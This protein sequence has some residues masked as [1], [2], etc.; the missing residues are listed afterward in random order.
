[1]FSRTFYQLHQ[2]SLFPPITRGYMFLL[3]PR[4]SPAFHWLHAFPFPAHF[5]GYVICLSCF[6]AL[7]IGC[8]SFRFSPS[9]ALLTD[10]TVLLFPALSAGCMLFLFSR[11]SLVTL[12]CFSQC[13]PALTSVFAFPAHPSRLHHQEWENGD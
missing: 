10:C 5:I 9:P 2:F 4:F 7:F 3:F 1:M 11:L 12:F 13:F 8:T 6:P